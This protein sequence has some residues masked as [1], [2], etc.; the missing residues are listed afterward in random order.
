[1]LA[2]QTQVL[3]I[4]GR[5]EERDRVALKAY[6]HGFSYAAIARYVGR[7]VSTVRYRHRR[8]RERVRARLLELGLLEEEP[9]LRTAG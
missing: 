5:F 8:D 9:Q 6:A 2:A 7:P 3:A 1:M 4:L